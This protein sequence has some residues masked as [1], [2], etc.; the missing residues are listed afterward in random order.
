MERFIGS[1]FSRKERY[2][3]EKLLLFMWMEDWKLNKWDT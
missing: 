3:E 1:W 2:K